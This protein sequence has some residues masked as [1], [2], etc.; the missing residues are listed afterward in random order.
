[1]SPEA[2]HTAIAEACG[3]P[4]L[5]YYLK[6]DKT[7]LWAMHEAENTLTVAQRREYVRQCSVFGRVPFDT[8]HL[9][10]EQRAEAFL[11]TIGK[12]HD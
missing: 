10:A 4:S 9:T 11:R 7:A 3:Q 12:W 1:M 2:Q 5:G 8:L 6:D